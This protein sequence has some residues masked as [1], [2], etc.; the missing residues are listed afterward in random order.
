MCWIE[1]LAL[2]KVIRMSDRR[3]NSAST[4]AYPKIDAIH[5]AEAGGLP[6]INIIAAQ[7]RQSGR[8]IC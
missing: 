7:N 6:N 4:H 5:A 3:S 2:F 8:R 1:R